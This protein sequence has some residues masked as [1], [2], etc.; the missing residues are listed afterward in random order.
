MRTENK[1]ACKHFKGEENYSCSCFHGFIYSEHRIRFPGEQRKAFHFTRSVVA[2]GK[3]MTLRWQPCSA[4]LETQFISCFRTDGPYY[5]DKSWAS[6]S[7]V[8]H[9]EKSASRRIQR[10]NRYSSSL[11][12]T[13]N[14]LQQKDSCLHWHR[15]YICLMNNALHFCCSGCSYTQRRQDIV[16]GQPPLLCNAWSSSTTLL[17]AQR[18]FGNLFPDTTA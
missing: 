12:M 15:A 13:W 18:L 16:P 3:Q 5:S 9:L 10:W 4:A 7:S 1:L 17:P 8:S 6:C 14:Y 11:G 2:Q